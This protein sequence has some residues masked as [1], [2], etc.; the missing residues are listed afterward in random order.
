MIPDTPLADP[1][2]PHP[3]VRREWFAFLAL[4]LVTAG[5]AGYL[6]YRWSI[7]WMYAC[8]DGRPPGEPVELNGASYAF[9]QIKSAFIACLIMGVATMLT[10]LLYN[11]VLHV[12]VL[13]SIVILSGAAL[14]WLGI[15]ET[16]NTN[17]VSDRC[18][19]RVPPTWPA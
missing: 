18:V 17:Y 16:T 14:L 15:L 9:T 11:R 12:I 1:R 2:A 3:S 13:A 19:N 4:T 5:V 8:H 10:Y 7:E 6:Q